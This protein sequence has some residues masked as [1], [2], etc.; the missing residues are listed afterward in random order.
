MFCL[1]DGSR[2]NRRDRRVP[3]VA[4]LADPG[5]EGGHHGVVRAGTSSDY[6]VRTQPSKAQ[7]PPTLWGFKPR[8][9]RV[10]AHHCPHS[11]A[12]QLAVEVQV[13]IR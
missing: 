7:F 3:D 5:A 10:P 11:A 12:D 2:H 1:T 8:L 6:A 4:R 13:Y 9:V